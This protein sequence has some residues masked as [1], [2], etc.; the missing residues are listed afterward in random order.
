M[1]DRGVVVADLARMRVSSSV[2]RNP[3]ISGLRLSDNR[4]KSPLHLRR[5]LVSTTLLAGTPNWRPVT[6]RGELGRYFVTALRFCTCGCGDGGSVVGQGRGWPKGAQWFFARK[7]CGAFK[8][9][10]R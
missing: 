8:G 3:S 6:K 10:I 4:H 9:F 2:K 5:S 1:P 7:S